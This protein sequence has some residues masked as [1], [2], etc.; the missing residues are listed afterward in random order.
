MKAKHTHRGHCQACGAVQ[1]VAAGL[2]TGVL[3]KHGYVVAGLGY[4]SGTCRGSKRLPLEVDHTYTDQVIR[5]LHAHADNAE[6]SAL[7][8]GRG[9]YTPPHIVTGERDTGRRDARQRRI[10]EDVLT[11]WA[12]CTEAQRREWVERTCKEYTNEAMRARQHAKDLAALVI[13]VHGQPL[14][15][16]A[17]PPK[18]VEPGLVFTHYGREWRVR[19]LV[20]S[21]F[22]SRTPNYAV[23]ERTDGATLSETELRAAIKERRKVDV[24]HRPLSIHTR[25]LR[26]VL[27]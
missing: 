19:K 3:A 5:E 11:D 9:E 4:F 20:T 17:P 13:R 22:R 24:E 15:P 12:D 25:S 23:C 8:V 16:A 18:T 21:G 26:K 7:R 6:V 27:S 14:T 2:V 1:A 10:Y